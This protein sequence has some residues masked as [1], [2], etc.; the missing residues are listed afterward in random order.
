MSISAG[1]STLVTAT[2]TLGTQSTTYIT[3]ALAIS[4][5]KSILSD[6]ITA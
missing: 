1:Q 6:D 2:K 5:P 4:L 3:L